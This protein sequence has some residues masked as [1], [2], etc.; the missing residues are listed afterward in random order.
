MV[1]SDSRIDA[2]LIQ[3]P[4][5]CKATLKTILRTASLL[6]WIIWNKWPLSLCVVTHE[7][8]YR[9]PCSLGQFD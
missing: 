3:L 9:V 8:I 6:L 1:K 5:S 7:V 2:L 4:C